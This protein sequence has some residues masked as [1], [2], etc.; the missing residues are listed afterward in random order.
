MFVY[1]A[2]AFARLD[3]AREVMARVQSEGYVLAHDWTTEDPDGDLRRYA[4]LDIA[5]V[6]NSDVLLVLPAAESCGTYWECG[7][8]LAWGKTIVLVDGYGGRECIFEH[9]DGVHRVAS[10]DQAFAYLRMI[11]R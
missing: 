9:A 2:T 8:A 4:A 7:L 10:L 5:G 1:V 3:L 6:H 11:A